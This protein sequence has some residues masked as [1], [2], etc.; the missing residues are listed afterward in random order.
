MQS[1]SVE[2]FRRVG[3]EACEEASSGAALGRRALRRRKR[4]RRESA[5]DRPRVAEDD[6]KLDPC[7][8]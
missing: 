6:Q 1:E 7:G 2:E 4:P 8:A 3:V 5:K